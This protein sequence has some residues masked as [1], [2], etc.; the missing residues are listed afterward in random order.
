MRYSEVVEHGGCI[1]INCSGRAKNN[2]IDLVGKRVHSLIIFSGFGRIRNN[3]WG[4]WVV[5]GSV[6]NLPASFLQF[7][8][9][10]EML[11]AFGTTCRVIRG[12][13]C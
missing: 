1:T 12:G 7:M 4:S 8:D 3:M 2:Y 5:D 6:K 9:E 10:S 13:S 11:H